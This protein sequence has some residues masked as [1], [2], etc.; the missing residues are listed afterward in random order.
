MNGFKAIACQVICG[1]LFS[2]SQAADPSW[3]LGRDASGNLKV[4]AGVAINGAKDNVITFLKN[5]TQTEFH[6]FKLTKF[7]E[8]GPCSPTSYQAC[9][10]CDAVF[11]DG[12]VDGY[13]GKAPGGPTC[14]PGLSCGESNDILRLQPDRGIRHWFLKNIVAKN[15]Y[16]SDGAQ[17]LDLLQTYL[18]PDY[19][20]WL[21]IQDSDFRNSD[22]Q[23][24]LLALGG[25]APGKPDSS[26][27]GNFVDGVV[28]QGTVFKQDSAYIQDCLGRGGSPCRSSVQ[29]SS[30]TDDGVPYVWFID[31]ES[32]PSI[33]I[34]STSENL[35]KNIVVVGPRQVDVKFPD[36]QKTI[37][38]FKYDRIEDALAAGIPEPP[39]IRLSAAGWR[40]P[41][42][43]LASSEKRVGFSQSLLLERT[44]SRE[45]KVVLPP[46]HFHV[47]LF[48]FQGRSLGVRRD[49]VEVAHFPEAREASGLHFLR[50]MSQGIQSLK[51]VIL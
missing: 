40:N 50:V 44:L 46:G 13:A 27:G 17:H 36:G 16:K 5:G 22:S 11:Y 23:H 41:T 1:L 31:V 26:C 2:M 3:S 33:L 43:A 12:V 37:K 19:H 9:E 10:P 47:E 39:F 18:A 6:D 21:V 32:D 51:P 35:F 14:V 8:P 38:L 45:L 29:F 4:N 7:V 30:G 48:D 24:L 20:G 15:G 25:E 49:A 34:R 28:I 42:T